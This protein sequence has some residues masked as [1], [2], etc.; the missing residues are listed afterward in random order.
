MKKLI[1]I[2]L[3]LITATTSA[4]TSVSGLPRHDHSSVAK[5]GTTLSA[6][7]GASLVLLQATNIGGGSSADISLPTGYDIYYFRIVAA[8]PATNA[9]EFA[10]RVSTDNGSTYDTASNYHFAIACL[11]T[12]GTAANRTT[13]AGGYFG[14]TLAGGVSVTNTERSLNG[15]VIFYKPGSTTFSKR[16]QSVLTYYDGTNEQHCQ[17]S[18]KYNVSGSGITNVRFFW[19]SGNW[20]AG[21]MYI[22]GEKVS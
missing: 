8:Q 13:A 1:V 7:A 6:A 14:F 4:A 18:G 12:A 20:T 3:C 11:N 16:V 19:S 17:G 2:A 5:G 9:V 22:Y 10:I 21:T 15:T